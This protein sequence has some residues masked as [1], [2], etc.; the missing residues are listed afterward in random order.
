MSNALVNT[1]LEIPTHHT[2]SDVFAALLLCT[3]TKLS[4]LDFFGTKHLH[5]KESDFGAKGEG[6]AGIEDHEALMVSQCVPN[7]EEFLFAEGMVEMG[8]MIEIFFALE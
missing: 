3:S 8:W 5:G 6:M 4:M 2:I 7:V 1:E